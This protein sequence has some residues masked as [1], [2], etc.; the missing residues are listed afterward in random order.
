[1]DGHDASWTA[2][3]IPTGGSVIGV[4]CPS[5]SLCVAGDTGGNVLT[6][7]NPTGGS[8]AW[9]SAL[10]DTPP[11][12]NAQSCLVAQLY[13]YDNQGTRVLDSTP[14]GAGNSLTS[15]KLSANLL[16]WSNHGTPHQATLR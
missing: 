12:C 5:A 11:S 1:V 8:S 4:S 14:P 7:T 9:S 3:K 6:S 15:V 2:T 10:I 16:T 13:A